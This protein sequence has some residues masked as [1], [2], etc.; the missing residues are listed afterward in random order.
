METG[1]K[2]DL[3]VDS[4]ATAEPALDVLLNE[5]IPEGVEVTKKPVGKATCYILKAR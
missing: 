1:S 2:E 3:K 5:I 4:P